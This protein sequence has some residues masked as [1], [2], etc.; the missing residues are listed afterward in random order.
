[1]NEQMT[2]NGIGDEGADHICEMLELNTTL[3]ELH[4]KRVYKQRKTQ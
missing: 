4:L 2:V 1:M 3:K